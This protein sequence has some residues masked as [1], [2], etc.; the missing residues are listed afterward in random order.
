MVLATLAAFMDEITRQ[1]PA[2]SVPTV[3]R[4]FTGAWADDPLTYADA[5][6]SKRRR[7]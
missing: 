3:R 2:S 7:R 6:V 5:F 1:R 4:D